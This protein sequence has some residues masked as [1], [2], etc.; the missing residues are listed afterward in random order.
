MYL[1][2][3][4]RADLVDGGLVLAKYVDGSPQWSDADWFSWPVC[5]LPVD[6]DLDGV[7]GVHAAM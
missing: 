7:S 3:Q 2:N 6:Q 5:S 4:W 1:D